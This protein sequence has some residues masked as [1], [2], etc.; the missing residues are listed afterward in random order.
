MG[1]ELLEK[2][3]AAEEG[4]R[5]LDVAIAW[6]IDYDPPPYT[7]IHQCPRYTTSLD[8]AI[9]L[10]PSDH[11]WDISVDLENKRAYATVGDDVWDE[12]HAV[13]KTTAATPALA[14]VVASLKAHEQ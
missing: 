10:I 8:A 6:A 12:C 4:S 14:I 13:I 9:T 1:V 11:E 7:N 5:E 3:E 2:L